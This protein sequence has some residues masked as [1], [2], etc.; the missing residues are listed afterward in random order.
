LRAGRNAGRPAAPI[1]KAKAKAKAKAQ[2]AP[3]PAPPPP[4]PVGRLP[5]L[6]VDVMTPEAWYAAMIDSVEE[7]SEVIIGSYQYDHEGLTHVLERRL[8]GRAPFDLTILLDREMYNS[9]TPHGQGS[10]LNMLK[11]LSAEL[12]LCRGTRSSGSFHAKA[13]VIDRRTAYVGSANIT[14]KSLR[15]GEL[16]L[17]LRGAPVAEILQFL[18]NEKARGFV[19]Q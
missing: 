19:A 9:N 4:A 1:A 12:V 16:C 2:L 7:A 5:D 11:R 15:N 3:A 8:R 18:H 14:N 13:V 6:A 10:R 17:V